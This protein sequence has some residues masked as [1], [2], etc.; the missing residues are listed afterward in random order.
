AAMK[1]AGGGVNIVGY[2][3][4]V[5]SEQRNIEIGQSRANAAATLLAAQG[6]DRA[7]LHIVARSA[8]A[9]TGRDADLRARRVIFE[10]AP[11]DEV[12]P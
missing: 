4:A 5:G 6:V 3:D 12:R 2:T 11:A 7:R 9:H 8:P 10:L 1:G